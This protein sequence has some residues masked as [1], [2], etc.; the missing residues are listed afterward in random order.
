MLH[1]LAAALTDAIEDAPHTT[2]EHARCFGCSRG[3][4]DRHFGR[5][6]RS[7][8]LSSDKSRVISRPTMNHSPA[9]IYIAGI[10]TIQTLD[11]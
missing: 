4:R 2:D 1:T 11:A 5:W 9:C 7:P 8:G 3:V 6:F 10:E